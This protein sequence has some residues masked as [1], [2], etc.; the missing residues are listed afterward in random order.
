[1]ASHHH[2]NLPHPHRPPIHH[3]PRNVP[4]TT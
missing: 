4:S 3:R 2:N 1:V